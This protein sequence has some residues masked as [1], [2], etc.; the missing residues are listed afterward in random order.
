MATETLLEYRPTTSADMPFLIALR[1]VTM[2]EHS[3]PV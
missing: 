3:V 2:D 1:H